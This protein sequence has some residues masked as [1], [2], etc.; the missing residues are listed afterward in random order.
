IQH[1]LAFLREQGTID[2]DRIGILGWGMAGG[3]VVDVA[4]KETDV[5]AVAVLNGF[6]DGKAFYKYAFPG[7]AFAELERRIEKE[8]AHRVLT[9]K[10]TFTNPFESYPLD[11]DTANVVD[12]RL[13]PVKNYEI[14]VSFEIAGSI[15]RFNA[16]ERVD[17]LDCPLFVAHGKDN[18]LHPIE[19]SERL[20]QMATVA[21]HFHTI[22]GKHNDFMT[23][24]HPMFQELARELIAW[25]DDV[26]K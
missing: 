16:L 5:K 7:N 8:R 21:K 26:L 2:P 6:F 3:L 19:Q 22:D 13:R 23:Y 24:E 14:T 11:P 12:D 4:S 25:C 15:M 10:L 20:Y 18:R 9:G 1:A 17:R